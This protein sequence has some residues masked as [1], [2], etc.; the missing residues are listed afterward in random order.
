MLETQLK[1]V[2]LNRVPAA[3]MRFCSCDRKTGAVVTKPKFLVLLIRV[4]NA[5][6]SRH[7][8]SH[9]RQ[10]RFPTA[11]KSSRYFFTDNF[12]QFC[13]I[14]ISF[15]YKIFLKYF[16]FLIVLKLL[17]SNIISAHIMNGMLN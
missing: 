8:I 13:F 17:Q 15:D 9:R 5:S 7:I 16:F 1:R 4:S 11:Y 14:S 10:Y 3:R 6:E 12:L 2:R